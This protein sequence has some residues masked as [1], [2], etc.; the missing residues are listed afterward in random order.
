[1]DTI[2]SPAAT[3]TRNV[4]GMTAKFTLGLIERSECGALTDVAIREDER[5]SMRAVPS[6][7]RAGLVTVRRD[8]AW[9]ENDRGGMDLVPD[10]ATVRLTYCPE[11]GRDKR[12]DMDLC[13]C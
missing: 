8:E 1:M 5:A 7:E 3:R 12:H 13:G 9:L 11:C 6:L 10:V 2:T 4:R